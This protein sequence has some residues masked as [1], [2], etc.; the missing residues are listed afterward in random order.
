MRQIKVKNGQTIL[1]IAVQYCGDVE[2]AFDIAAMN[3]IEVT[4]QPETGTV[5]L[6]PEIS[7]KRVVSYFGANNIAPA[8]EYSSQI[9]FIPMN[10]IVKTENYN[11][12]NGDHETEDVVSRGIAVAVQANFDSVAGNGLQAKLQES[13]TGVAD[14]FVDIP[15][16]RVDIS[17][18]Q[19]THMWNLF[20][21]PEGL[22]I[23]IKIIAPSNTGYLTTW[24]ML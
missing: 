17:A 13:I 19:T 22:H 12:A 18:G 10:A 7:N 1:D 6:I 4:S 21:Y 8:T 2:A 5:L 9:N 11:L 16:S 20:G 23:R 24:W 3:D 14:S 15:N